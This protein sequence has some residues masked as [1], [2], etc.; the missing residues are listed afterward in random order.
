MNVEFVG[1]GTQK[2]SWMKNLLDPSEYDPG[3][4]TYS[5]NCNA[6]DA[7]MNQTS[8]M[9]SSICHDDV[10]IPYEVTTKQFD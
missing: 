9:N 8:S 5:M 1:H 2:S 6:N 10:A 7:D 4:F 3:M